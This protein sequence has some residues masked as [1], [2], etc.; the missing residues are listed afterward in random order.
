MEMYLQPTI[1]LYVMFPLLLQ[2]MLA[3]HYTLTIFTVCKDNNNTI[4]FPV[5]FRTD[6]TLSI[7]TSVLSL[8][9]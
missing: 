8:A 7:V 1:Q 4:K 3:D 5:M 2:Q 6:Q 9:W